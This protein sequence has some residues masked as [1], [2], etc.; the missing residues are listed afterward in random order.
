ME[1]A[2]PGTVAGEETAS[3]NSGGVE[4]WRC[5][6]CEDTSG[7]VPT[8]RI[9]NEAWHGPCFL[10]CSEC[11]DAL[12]SLYYEKDSK[13]YC[14]KDYWEKFGE[15]CHGCSLLMTGPVMVAGD[16][17]YH[18]ECFACMSCKVIIE[19]GET[20]ALVQ[21]ST[22]YCGKCHN[23][24]VLGPMFERL[25]TNPPHEQLPYTLTLVSI[26]A[27]TNG[28]RGFSVSV[29]GASSSNSTGVQVKECKI[30]FT[31]LGRNYSCWLNM[32][33]C[34]SSASELSRGLGCGLHQDLPPPPSQAR[35]AKKCLMS[36][37]GGAPSGAVTVSVN[38]QGH[39]LQRSRVQQ[40]ETLAAQSLFAP[41]AAAHSRSSGPATLCM[42]R[43]W[44]KASLVRPSR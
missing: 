15:L 19:D 38:P 41:P 40:A 42:E 24:L 28:N 4:I 44:V 18:P 1:E 16:Y 27:A 36:D 6:G 13:L 17:K 2:S 43:C 12:T 20:Y 29:E 33:P 3:E 22:L 37:C 31:V 9:L 26:P 23:L 10:R 35:I 30:C 34:H 7:R 8:I 21:H 11:C 32:T 25:S 39:P 14:H 5:R